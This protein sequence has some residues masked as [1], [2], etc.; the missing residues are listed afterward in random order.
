[1]TKYKFTHIPFLAIPLGLVLATSLPV[2]ADEDDDDNEIPFAEAHLFFELNNTDGDLGIHSLIDGDPWKRL[3]I[4]DPNERRMLA[5]NV[6]GRLKRQGL[7]EIF[8]ESAEPRFSELSPK[9]FFR[10]FPQ[11][12]YE[13][14]GVTLDN[15]ELES[16][17]EVTHVMPAPAQA[18]INGKPMGLQCDDELTGYDAPEVQAPVTISWEEVT[19]SHPD[20]NGGGAGVQPPVPVTINNYEV[21]VEYENGDEFV[22]VLGVTL[23]PSETSMTVPEELLALAESDDAFKFE[24]LAREKSYNQTAVESCFV[25]LD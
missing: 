6:R 17:T 7:T 8:F 12:T 2:F 19:L 14:E 24:I 15:L 13:I 9:R 20:P 16:E 3:R 4:E 23:P 1:M 10:R 11:G 22:S 18:F 5:V 21:V 25:L